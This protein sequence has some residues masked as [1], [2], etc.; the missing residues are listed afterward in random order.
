MGLNSQ[1]AAE[2]NQT[3]TETVTWLRDATIAFPY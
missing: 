1:S 2:V 3:D